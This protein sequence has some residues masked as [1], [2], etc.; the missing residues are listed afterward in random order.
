METMCEDKEKMRTMFDRI[1]GKK[2]NEEHDL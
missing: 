1:E 2:G